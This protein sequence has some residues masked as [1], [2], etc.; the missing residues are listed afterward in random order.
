MIKDYEPNRKKIKH[1]ST[2]ITAE[3]TL[4][5]AAATLCAVRP[6]IAGEGAV[7]PDHAMARHHNADGV[8][9]I[10]RTDR[11]RRA[12]TAKLLCQLTVVHHLPAGNITQRL[13]HLALE[14]GTR[15]GGWQGINNAEIALE[16]GRQFIAQPAGLRAVIRS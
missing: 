12:G 11:A 15:R 5:D 9:A 4:R 1:K 7:A 8:R 13:P 16:V 3:N 6:G 14:R 2:G 10:C